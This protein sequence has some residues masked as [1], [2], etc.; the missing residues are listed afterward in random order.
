[1]DTNRDVLLGVLA[2]QSGAIDAGQ[3]QEAYKA[4]VEDRRTPLADVLQSRGWLSP[5]QRRGLEQDLEFKLSASVAAPGGGGGDGTQVGLDLTNLP[6]TVAET[7]AGTAADTMAATRGGSLDSARPEDGATLDATAALTNPGHDPSGATQQ[8][9]VDFLTNSQAGARALQETAQAGSHALVTPLGT[10]GEGVEKY[11]RTRLHA[12]GGIGQVWLAR[13]DTLGREV[14]L[15]ELRPDRSHDRVVWNRFFEEARIT[16]QL[17]H[18]GI[19]PIY[20]LAKEPD[21]HRPYYTMRFVRGSTLSEAIKSYH[22]KRLAGT[23]GPLE[24]A[25]LLDVFVSVCNAVA[26]A[27]SRWVLHRDLKG[28]N[29]VLGEFG[30]VMVLDWGLAKIFDQA[31]PDDPGQAPSVSRVADPEHP[32]DQT[33]QGQ[34]LGTPAYMAPEQAAG[35]IKQIDRRTDIYALGTILYEIIAGEPPFKATTLTEVLRKVLEEP[36]TPPRVANPSAPAALG[37]VALKAMAKRPDDRYQDVAELAR[38]VKRWLADEPVL[39]FPEP[40]TKRVGRWAKRHRNAVAAGAAVAMIGVSALGVGTVLIRN[41]RNAARLQREYARTAVD[42]MYT[43][44]AETFL[45]DHSDPL[46]RKFLDR[47]LAYYERFSREDAT[48]PKAVEERGR[49]YQRLGDV[50]RKL[51]RH[52]E[53]E[54][55]YIEATKILGALAASDPTDPEHRRQLA[56]SWSR[57]GLAYFDRGADKD[58]AEAYGKALGAQK[59]LVKSPGSTDAYRRDLAL[60]QKGQADLE[61]RIGAFGTAETT[62]REAL[63]IETDLR[64]AHPDDVDYRHDVAVID[65]A[66]GLVLKELGKTAESE[67]AYREAIAL[68]EE[69]V[70]ASPTSP[71]LREALAKTYNSLAL[72]VRQGGSAKEEETCLNRQLELLQRL[73]DDYPLRPE[74]RRT[75]S[76][77]HLNLGMMLWNDGRR[78]AAKPHI[79]EAIAHNVKLTADAPQ[80]VQYR[81]DLA[82]DRI[83]FAL[84]LRSAGELQDAATVLKEDRAACEALLSEFPDVPRHKQVLAQVNNRLAITLRELGDAA[85]SE[86]AFLRSV[87]LYESLVDAAPANVEYRRELGDCLN[88]MGLLI[89]ATPAR[90]PDAEAILRRSVALLEKV[91]VEQPSREYRRGLGQALSNL[92]LLRPA[93][94]PLVFARA[95]EVYNKLSEEFPDVADYR[96]QLAA[97]RNNHGEYELAQGHADQALEQFNAAII[98]LEALA[99]ELPKVPSY[100]STLGYVLQQKGG[101][102]RDRKQLAEARASFERAAEAQRQALAVDPKLGVATARLAQHLKSLAGVLQDQGEIVAAAKVAEDLRAVYPKQPRGPEAAAR[103]LAVCAGL[104]G[105]NA[106]LS[107]QERVELGKSLGD[108]SIAL[109]QEMVELGGVQLLPKPGDPSFAALAD[110]D[111]FKALIQRKVEPAPA[112]GP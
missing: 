83:N 97:V 50:L 24:L 18:P 80:I 45:E 64:K 67:R 32:L 35:R 52:E 46:Q 95:Q 86:D 40:W 94:A 57:L 58:A 19:V 3:F 48:D 17:E 85:E 36:P 98:G 68:Q 55:A 82:K 71:K 22:E 26:Y 101:L 111:D 42:E 78:D 61:R 75:L 88:S 41:E 27:H 47:A 99:V 109:L 8:A 13:D 91:A 92:G 2:F 77:A 60:T 38:E 69:M 73:A 29:V 37:A 90:R 20:E 44:V 39:A 6:A 79:R 93:D 84:L 104:A 103:M 89:A 53:A 59:I 66:L 23:A 105:S 51:G 102:L 7:L 15:K 112:G 54:K 106:K 14:A 1:M 33:Q 28:Q 74:Y 49:A 70:A 4:W 81:L 5:D 11:T 62:Y 10:H 107:E 16:G 110:R 25:A 30:E 12:K 9:T 31:G 43:D 108:R 100:P 21:S 34:V 96:M 87:K 63:A 56:R 76:R 72:L 65:D